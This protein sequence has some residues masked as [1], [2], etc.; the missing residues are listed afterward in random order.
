LYDPENLL[1]LG[2]LKLDVCGNTSGVDGK[3]SGCG[4]PVG[5]FAVTGTASSVF[6]TPNFL[7][8]ADAADENN[9]PIHVNIPIPDPKNTNP[10][11]IIASMMTIINMISNLLSPSIIYQYQKI[12]KFL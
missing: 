8:V 12:E 6:K 1:F 5:S 7:P 3:T 2:C 4:T 10:Y 11:I 9:D